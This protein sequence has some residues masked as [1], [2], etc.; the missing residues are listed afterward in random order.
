MRGSRL[1]EVLRAARR[2]KTCRELKALG[3]ERIKGEQDRS[4]V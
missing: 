1:R 2:H 4:S 3:R